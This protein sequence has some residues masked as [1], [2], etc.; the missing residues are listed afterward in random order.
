M[1]M[2]EHKKLT[3][4]KRQAV[5]PRLSQCQL[6]RDSECV[7]KTPHGVETRSHSRETFWSPCLRRGFLFGSRYPQTKWRCLQLQASKC[8][9]STT[10]SA[11]RHKKTRCDAHIGPGDGG[12]DNMAQPLAT[13]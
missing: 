10:T 8:L 7:R 13:A 5:Y 11:S 9:K 6:G 3:E 4:D 2:A 12:T 1:E